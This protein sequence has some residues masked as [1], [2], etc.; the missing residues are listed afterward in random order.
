M[1][2]P[3]KRTTPFTNSFCEADFMAPDITEETTLGGIYSIPGEGF[4]VELV[5]GGTTHLFD[6]QG[7]QY[8]ILE[9][10]QR[11]LDASVEESALAQVNNVGSA[12]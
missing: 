3:K 5:Q 8:R 12:L 9:K 6:K 4:V 2:T 1:I 7:L 10:R 11:G